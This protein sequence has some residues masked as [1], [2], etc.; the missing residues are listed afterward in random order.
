MATTKERIL[1]TLGSG[2][3]RAIRA[4]A[5]REG[6]PR[7]TIAARAVRHWLEDEEDRELVRIVRE[8]D[9]SGV[10]YLTHKEFWKCVEDRRHGK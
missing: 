8:R 10:K 3:A 7:A 4:V 1:I 5:K 6:R 2:E 9:I